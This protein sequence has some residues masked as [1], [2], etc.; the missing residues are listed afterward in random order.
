MT[1]VVQ[2]TSTLCIHVNF[3]CDSQ[4]MLSPHHLVAAMA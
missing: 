4:T 1:G 2:N 3:S